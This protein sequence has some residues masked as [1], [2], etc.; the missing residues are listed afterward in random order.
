MWR[1]RQRVMAGARRS[2]AEMTALFR[3]YRMSFAELLD[4]GAAANGKR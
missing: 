2:P 1:K 4:A 3:R